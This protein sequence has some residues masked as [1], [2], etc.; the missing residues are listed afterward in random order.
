M[1]SLAF[2]GGLRTHPE[3]GQSTKSDIL[4]VAGPIA[5]VRAP[6]P[7]T[8]NAMIPLRF[9]FGKT[10]AM[11]SIRCVIGR[12]FGAYSLRL[13]GLR[14]DN[15]FVPGAS[16]LAQRWQALVF[17]LHGELR[18]DGERLGERRVL[19]AALRSLTSTGDP[20][21]HVVSSDSE[22]VALR[23]RADVVASPAQGARI[24]S[25][26]PGTAEAL[27]ALAP[28]V[29]A[30]D[31][32]AALAQTRAA[33]RALALDHILTEG[34]DLPSEE[35]NGSLVARA[36]SSIFPIVSKLATKPMLVDVVARTGI[37]E[38][39]ILRDFLKVQVE[40]DLLDRGWRE[41]LVRWRTT[42]AVLLLSVDRLSIEEIAALAGYSG[43]TA[44]G[45]ALRE[46]G[47]PTASAIRAGLREGAGVS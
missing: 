22:L 36:V 31:L 28:C 8:G 29:K 23:L 33:V 10:G 19:L 21:P 12:Q 42:L 15:R 13:D 17:P 5:Y 16:V 26:S 41:S 6:E 9:D 20:M 38:R 3:A 34:A 46:A 30:G 7:T 32:E 47:L 25:I 35:P 11:A 24:A 4:P 45:R 14:V 43:P 18:L 40:Y 1:M 2:A 37:S 44:M 27:R 39:Q